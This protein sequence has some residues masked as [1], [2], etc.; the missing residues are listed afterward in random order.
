M[1]IST[2]NK[3]ALRATEIALKLALKQVLAATAKFGATGAAAGLRDPDAMEVDTVILAAMHWCAFAD[4]YGI[5]LSA[6]PGTIMDAL[7]VLHATEDLR[8][9]AGC[10]CATA[11]PWAQAERRILASAPRLRKELQRQKKQKRHA[12]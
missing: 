10:H 4:Y 2:G 7:T 12:G 9:A 5:G 3:D 6:A 11:G 8:Q 1:A